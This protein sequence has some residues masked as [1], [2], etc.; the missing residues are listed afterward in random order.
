MTV[1]NLNEQAAQ[2]ASSWKSKVLGNPAGVNFKVLRMDG[3]PYPD[4]VHDF[5]EALLVIDGCMRLDIQSQV[6]EVHTGEVCIVPAGMPHGVAAGS[7][8]TLVIIDPRD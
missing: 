5:D 7:H 1:I 4:E 6:T 8:G 3:S 2:L